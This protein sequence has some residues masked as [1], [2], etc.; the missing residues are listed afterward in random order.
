MNNDSICGI[1]ANRLHCFIKTITV[2]CLIDSIRICADHID[3]KFFQHAFSRQIQRTIQCRLPTHGWQQSVRTLFLNNFCNR[4]PLYRLNVR[5]IRHGWISHDRG[6][7]RIHQNNP[8]TL[9][10]Q[11]FTSLGARVIKLTCLTNNNRACTEDENTFYISS[12]WHKLLFILAL[13]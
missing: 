4:A 3:T 5:C 10:P 6:R 13:S 8:K 2:F 7:V 9:F 12:F 1:K 11:G